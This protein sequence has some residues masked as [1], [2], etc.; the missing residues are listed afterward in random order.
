MLSHYLFQKPGTSVLRA[1]WLYHHDICIVELCG[2]RSRVCVLE[3]SIM[4]AAGVSYHYEFIDGEFYL[5][6]VLV[7]IIEIEYIW[8]AKLLYFSGI[9]F[10]WSWA[11]DDLDVAWIASHMG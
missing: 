1:A 10:D 2:G 8:D 6:S 4:A 3:R 9:L 7:N 5:G 11:V